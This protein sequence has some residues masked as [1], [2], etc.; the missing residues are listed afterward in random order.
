MLGNWYKLGLLN[1]DVNP[2]SIEF[3]REHEVNAGT[4][5]LVCDCEDSLFVISSIR[6]VK[7]NT[8][9]EIEDPEIR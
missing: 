7:I 9:D 5:L 8:S 4:R 6:V 3:S 2:E 1:L